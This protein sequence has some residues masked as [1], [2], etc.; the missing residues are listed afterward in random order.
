GFIRDGRPLL[1]GWIADYLEYGKL[2][3][4]RQDGCTVYE[5][6]KAQLGD[7]ITASD[8]NEI[9]VIQNV[10]ALHSAT[11]AY[12]AAKL[13]RIAAKTLS[14]RGVTKYRQDLKKKEID[15]K[16]TMDTLMDYFTN[17]QLKPL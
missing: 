4:I 12:E 16:K 15:M 7:N 5:I 9:E 1:A 2:L 6:A 10:Y 3:Q 17:R 14:F 11:K 13:Q 8:R